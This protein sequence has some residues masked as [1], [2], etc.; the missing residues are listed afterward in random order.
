MRTAENLT[1]IEAGRRRSSFLREAAEYRELLALLAWR[2]I[3]V[4][5]KQTVL[6]IGWAVFR[7]A[8]T[9][10]IFVAVFGLFAR[11]PSPD[12]PYPLLVLAGLLIWQLLAAATLGAADSLLGNAP[13]LSKV[14]FP[15]V[16]FPLSAS[17]SPL[18]DF[19]VGA[20]VLGLLMGWYG[21]APTWRLAA[22]PVLVLVALCLAV[23]VGTWLSAAA[24]RYRDL[25]QVAPFAVQIGLYV[26]PVAY[27]ISL[28]PERWQL[29]YAINPAV[30]LIDGFR[31]ALLGQAQLNLPA[32]GISVAAAG[33]A[34]AGGLAYFRRVERGLV[35][36]L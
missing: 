3:S 15:R 26:S 35:D 9:T 23:G 1:V 24:V 32:L 21:V 22:L 25:R 11:V 36:I 12:I 34:L 19:A 31:W 6:G 4:R 8:I 17:A 29:V 16:I 30:G 27:P 20:L 14:Y 33:L 2:D 28:V 10:L 13:M 18:A 7:P 5:Y